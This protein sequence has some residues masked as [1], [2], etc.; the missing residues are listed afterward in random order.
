MPTSKDP[1]QDQD[2]SSFLGEVWSRRAQGLPPISDVLGAIKPEDVQYLCDHFYPYLQIIS[3][4]ADL[5]NIVEPIFITADSDWII[6]DYGIAL[7][8]SPGQYLFGNY[9][10]REEGESGEGGGET[11]LLP[12]KGTIVWQQVQTAYNMVA[13]AQEKGWTGIELVDGTPKMKWAAWMAAQDL[14]LE[15]SGYDPSEQDQARR[16][17]IQKLLAEVTPSAAQG[18][19]PGR[20]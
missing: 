14:G 18:I 10:A 7:S 1:Y 4:E 5:E 19:S 3:A 9:W 16:K 13:I 6:H 2:L 11:V 20:K 15:L 8:S 17:R 12:G